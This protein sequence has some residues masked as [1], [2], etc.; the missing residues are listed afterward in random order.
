MLGWYVAHSKPQKEEWLYNQ[1]RALQFEAYYPCLCA[2]NGKS[3]S[4][5]SRPYFPGYLF[6]NVDLDLTGV[7][8]LQWIPGSLGLVTFGGEPASVPDTLLQRIRYRVNEIN[9]AGDKMLDVLKLGDEVAI[10]S[11]LFA[12]HDAIFCA[13]LH[14]SERVQ[15]LLKVLQDRVIRIDLQVNQITITKQ[16][17]SLL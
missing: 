4:H 16:N 1:L 8:V 15:V 3:H 17:R 14:D 13:R 11:G 9:T 6:V 7:S 2:I 5:K 12:G 10:H